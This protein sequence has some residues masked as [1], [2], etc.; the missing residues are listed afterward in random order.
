MEHD[1]KEKHA[2]IEER[3]I[4]L[5]DLLINHC[6]PGAQRKLLNFIDLRIKNHY[7]NSLKTMEGNLKEMTEK[8]KQ[9]LGKGDEDIEEKRPSI[10]EQNRINTKY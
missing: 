1:S 7:E 6:N 8:Y 9:F 5:I 2:E 4:Q 10:A 3:A